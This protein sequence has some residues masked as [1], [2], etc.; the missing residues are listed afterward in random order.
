MRRAI[1]RASTSYGVG[2]FCRSFP[3]IRGPPPIFGDFVRGQTEATQPPIVIQY[4]LL[5]YEE[6]I[7]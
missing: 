7:N 3:K 6:D 2:I 4:L 5:S 1:M